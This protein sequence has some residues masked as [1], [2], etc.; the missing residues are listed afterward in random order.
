[1]QECHITGDK[2]REIEIIQAKEYSV[3]STSLLFVL[4]IQP[5]IL[6]I[7]FEGKLL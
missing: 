6:K 1:M 5:V 3:L 7:L 4:N 2:S